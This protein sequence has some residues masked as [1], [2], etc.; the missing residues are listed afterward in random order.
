MAGSYSGCA[1]GFLEAFILRHCLKISESS[2]PLL[3]AIEA[4]MNV[5]HVSITAKR[6]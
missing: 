2:I 5:N 3:A 4:K 1:Y 6:S